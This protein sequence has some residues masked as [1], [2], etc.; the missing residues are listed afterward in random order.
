MA[1]EEI[2][3]FFEDEE[4]VAGYQETYMKTVD[5]HLAG[6]EDE[7]Q[8][9]ELKTEFEKH[10]Q[11]HSTNAHADVSLNILRAESNL[12]K[13]ADMRSPE[14]AEIMDD[15]DARRG[16]GTARKILTKTGD[17][18]YLESITGRP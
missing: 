4:S 5:K 10:N 6:I 11:I 3:E 17:D 13:Q 12:K 15:I 8:R 2:T 18:A 9:E 7:G 16:K 1:N 14:L